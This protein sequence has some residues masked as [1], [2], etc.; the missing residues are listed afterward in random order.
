MSILKSILHHWNK[1]TSSYD[2]LHPETEVAQITDWSQGVANTL[3]STALG[4]LISTLSSD[5][6]AAKIM[7]LVLDATGVKYL[8]GTNGYI[9]FGSLVGGLIIQWGHV[10]F[11]NST[12]CDWI[13]P[14]QV[15]KV[16]QVLATD[17]DTSRTNG[18]SISDKYTATFKA[19]FS[20][21]QRLRF[22]TAS[23]SMGGF[24]GVVI[25]R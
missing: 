8:M 6:L 3:A 16:F 14:L 4:S 22:A 2:T 9:C 20:D 11:G 13:L 23:T 10:S 17:Y 15:S 7:K 12:Y 18:T 21:G 19:G 24:S 1:T 5:S 25:C